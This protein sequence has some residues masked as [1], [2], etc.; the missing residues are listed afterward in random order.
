MRAWWLAASWWGCASPDALV[1]EEPADFSTGCARRTY[2]RDGDGDGFG[3]PLTSLDLCPSESAG[4]VRNGEDCDDGDWETYPGATERCRD[5]VDRDCDGLVRNNAIDPRAWYLDEDADGFGG[6]RISWSC[7]PVESHVLVTG[8]CRD[9]DP[10]ICPGAIEAPCDGV[11]Q[12]CDGW[13]PKAHHGESMSDDFT[14]FFDDLDADHPVLVCPGTYSL[15]ATVVAERLELRG[16]G[17]KGSVVLQAASGRHLDLDVTDLLLNNL[18][19]EGGSVDGDGGSIR[20]RARNVL[21]QDVTFVG[22]RATGNGGAIWADLWVPDAVPW[23]LYLV[24]VDFEDT[25][26]DGDGGAVWTD[27]QIDGVYVRVDRSSAGGSGGAFFAE[28]KAWIYRSQASDT[29][30]GLDGGLAAGGSVSFD[31]DV[32]RSAAGRDGG[33]VAGESAGLTGIS[34]DT[35]ATRYGGAVYGINAGCSGEI[36]HSEASVGGALYAVQTAGLCHIHH[37]RATVGA[38]AWAGSVSSSSLSRAEITDNTGG[39]AVWFDLAPSRGYTSLFASFVGARNPGGLLR[40]P[41]GHKVE[42]LAGADLGEGADE[43]GVFDI[44]WGTKS[45]FLDAP[46]SFIWTCI[47]AVCT[48]VPEEE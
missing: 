15:S 39:V 16:L 48:G 10:D 18:R 17:P 47:D 45:T 9:R 29:S 43:N 30:A 41:L 1:Q 46:S 14:S 33:V 19:F 42:I 26:A 40:V 34:T 35:R 28:E 27:G 8:D 5:V 2:W 22:S 3:D 38:A 37:S 20:A 13:E 21:L 7:S 36:S 25:H 6:D 31:G 4:W 32:V 44:Q 23:K 24:H 11:D 12:D